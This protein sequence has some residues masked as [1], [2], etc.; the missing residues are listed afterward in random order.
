METE[1]H[2]D[3]KIRLDVAR[4]FSGVLETTFKFV[5][6][7]ITGLLKSVVVISVILQLAGTLIIAVGVGAGVFLNKSDNS[8]S[9]I[10]DIFDG[11]ETAQ[12]IV[13]FVH[14]LLLIVTGYVYESV[15]SAAYFRFY[16]EDFSLH[17]IDPQE[18]FDKILQLSSVKFLQ[19]LGFG[20]LMLLAVGVGMLFCIFPGIYV[21]I[22]LSFGT[23]VIV[24]DKAGIIEAFDQSVKHVKNHWWSTFGL[25]F[26]IGI[27]SAIFNLI[28]QTLATVSNSA[29]SEIT[30]LDIDGLMGLIP[31]FVI[32]LFTIGISS[33]LRLFQYA[34]IN[35]Q[36][37]SIL[38]KREGASLHQRIYDME[39][40]TL[41]SGDIT[42]STE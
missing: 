42:S 19:A 30:G 25:V 10:T 17:E 1:E 23:I 24:L 6:Q 26:L 22:A 28:I 9:T 5:R 27:I 4:D 29:F 7:E 35:V 16:R 14:G 12:S 32:S 15:S 18:R 40:S 8:L 37:Y 2:I 13:F 3:Y 41:P 11:S 34:I 36:Y 38:E 20:V 21:A 31:L 33:I 39:T